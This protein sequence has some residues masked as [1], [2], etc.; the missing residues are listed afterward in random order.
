MCDI[1]GAREEKGLP[2]LVVE[3]TSR[4]H[5]CRPN[6]TKLSEKIG[7]E[8]RLLS[9]LLVTRSWLKDVPEDIKEAIWQETLVCNISLVIIIIYKIL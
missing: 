2:K 9:T 1:A 5:F 8:A 4:E 6:K 3:V 7:V